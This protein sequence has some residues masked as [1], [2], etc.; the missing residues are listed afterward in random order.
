MKK[1][2]S[3]IAFI[4]ILGVFLSGCQK[5]NDGIVAKVGNINISQ[6]E[7]DEDYQVYKGLYEKQLGE[8]VLSQVGVDGKTFGETLKENILNKLIME[9]L[10]SEDSETMGITITDE[11]LKEYVDEYKISM[12]GEDGYLEFLESNNLSENFFINSMRKELLLN[13]HKENIIA[14]FNVDENEA[15]EYFQSNKDSLIEVRASHILLG[16]EED[17]IM[18]LERLDGGEKFDDLAKTESLDSVSGV[19]GGDLGYFPRGQMISEFEEIAFSLELGEISEVVKTEVGYHIIQLVDKLDTF[20]EL[21]EKVFV[22]IK[23]DKYFNYIEELKSKAD[24]EKYL[25]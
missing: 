8:D 13:S 11:D 17:A 16:S 10:I 20:D 24:I 14:G 15:E 5:S 1:V 25:D 18:I 22:V 6:E 7:F 21:E 19:K 23:E 12:G 9:T 4:L 3:I 2:I